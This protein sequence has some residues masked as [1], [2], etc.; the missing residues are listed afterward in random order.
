M[1]ALNAIAW[2][3]TGFMICGMTTIYTGLP[4]MKHT[5][6]FDP[7][8]SDDIAYVA[9]CA[10]IQLSQ[11][12]KKHSDDVFAKYEELSEGGPE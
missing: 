2:T 9:Q 12:E 7:C 3:F 1:K 11:K 10:D 5:A 6:R 4:E 8:K